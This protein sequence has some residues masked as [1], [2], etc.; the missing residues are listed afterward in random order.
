MD[1]LKGLYRESGEQLKKHLIPF[2]TGLMDTKRGGFFGRVADDLS[3]EK[4]ADRGSILNS[5]ILWF[6]S[7]AYLIAHEEEALPA[8]RHA[9]GYLKSA[10]LDPKNGGIYWSVTAK[11]KPADDS[12]H[13]YAQAFA[14]YGLSAYAHAERSCHLLS[15]RDGNTDDTA[16]EEALGIAYLLF[17]LIESKMRDEK[18][19]CEAFDRELHPVSNEKLSENGVEAARTMNTLLHVLEAYTELYLTDERK[20]VRDRICEILDIFLDKIYDRGSSRLGVF[21]DADYHSL[22]DLYSYGHDIEASWLIDRALDAVGDYDRE[23]EARG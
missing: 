13:C 18:G 4:D 20:E 11:G 6:F 12:K 23:A 7:S 5:R 2:W 22:I 3:V 15:I 16:A 17:E 21:F 1:D 8:A 19:Y 10:F 14:I 9:Y